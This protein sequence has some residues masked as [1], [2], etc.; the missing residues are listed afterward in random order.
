MVIVMT[1]LSSTIKLLM[2][3]FSLTMYSAV[4]DVLNIKDG[5]PTKYVV[6]KGDTLWDISKL[7]LDKAWLW[8]ELWRNNTQI[9]NPH[10]IYPGDTL[11]LRYENGVPILEVVRD[12]SSVTLTPNQRVIN[13][14]DPID[15]LPW[16][17]IAPFYNNDSL[18][19]AED[20]QA[21]PTLLGDNSG[22]PRF[23][24]HDYVLA[25][26]LPTTESKYQV[27]RK[28]RDIIDSKGKLLGVQ[29]SHLSDASLV[30][31][32][33][34]ERQVV[35]LTQSSREAKQG[36]KLLAYKAPQQKNLVLKAASSRSKGELVQNVNGNVLSGKNDMVIINIGS[37]QVK[38][39]T[40]FGIYYK[41]PDVL[42]EDEPSYTQTR[43][44]IVDVFSTKERVE[45]PAYKVG[46]LVVVKTF[47]NAS[48]AWVT[49]A[50]THIKGGEYIA[51]P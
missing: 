25:H 28:E 43:S 32:L 21:L 48:Y 31:E 41:G 39:G 19:S 47:K 16:D 17:I 20:Y 1:K 35:R 2:I 7:F 23:A 13:K 11:R 18:M 6:K 30:N 29:V 10:L 40:I 8:P 38:P 9:E 33:S 44:S 51:T 14:P 45:Q 3:V 36:D 46:E 5:A 12:K 24:T 37:R 26:K 34:N 15:L 4:A 50:N 42:Y 49:H 27:V 22:T